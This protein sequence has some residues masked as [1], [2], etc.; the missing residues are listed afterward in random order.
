MKYRARVMETYTAVR[1]GECSTLYEQLIECNGDNIYDY[2]SKCKE[3][4][5]SLQMCAVKNKLGE[6]SK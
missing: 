1:T 3:V 6:L 4:R 5:D 2:A